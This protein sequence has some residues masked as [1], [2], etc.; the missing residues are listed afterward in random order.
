MNF[1][2]DPEDIVVN[3]TLSKI[4]SYFHRYSRIKHDFFLFDLIWFLHV[5]FG[6]V[7][8]FKKKDNKS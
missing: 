4:N 5:V 2:Y 8:F 6:E 7:F 1:S 3:C